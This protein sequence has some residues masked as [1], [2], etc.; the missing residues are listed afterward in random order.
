MQVDLKNNTNGRPTVDLDA[1]LF[2]DIPDELYVSD[3]KELLFCSHFESIEIFAFC[4]K[5]FEI[6]QNAT[7]L[8]LFEIIFNSNKSLIFQINNIISRRASKEYHAVLKTGRINLCDFFKNPDREQFL[9]ALLANL[10]KFGHMLFN[11]PMEKV[12][13]HDI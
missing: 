6:G 10:E 5:L 12:N 1:E 11:C 8:K 2:I 3:A 13:I 7:N 9:K 4:I